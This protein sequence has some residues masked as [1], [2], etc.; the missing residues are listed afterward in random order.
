MGDKQVV[1][2][3]RADYAPQLNR[4][5][6]LTGVKGHYR[7]GDADEVYT[8]YVVDIRDGGNTIETKNTIYKKL[9]VDESK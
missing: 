6:L 7:L 8:S 5:A 9:D 2:F 4:R 3:T 1:M